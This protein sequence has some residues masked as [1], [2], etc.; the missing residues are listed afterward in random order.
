MAALSAMEQSAIESRI[1]V[2]MLNNGPTEVH[3]VIH[4]S[5]IALENTQKVDKTLPVR[6]RAL[7]L[8]HAL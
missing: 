3:R 6:R 2:T 1:L 8:I 5:N 4:Q 7:Q